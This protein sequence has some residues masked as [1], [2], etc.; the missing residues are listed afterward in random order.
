LRAHEDGTTRIDAACLIA[1]AR[2][3]EVPVGSFFDGLR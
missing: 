2:A 3:F 1:I